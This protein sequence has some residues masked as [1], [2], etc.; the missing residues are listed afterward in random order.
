MVGAAQ[1][2]ALQEGPSRVHAVFIRPVLQ[3]ASI[4][5]GPCTGRGSRRGAG[6]VSG[7]SA[8]L[9]DAGQVTQLPAVLQGRLWLHISWLLDRLQ[10]LGSLQREKGACLLRSARRSASHSGALPGLLQDVVL[11]SVNVPL[12][13]Y[14]LYY[15]FF[16]SLCDLSPAHLRH[17]PFSHPVH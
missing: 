16:L 4:S 2:E 9:S 8:L 14:I 3:E 7:R 12:P 1:E 13:I 11:R 10:Q 17:L 5:K 6:L 15:S